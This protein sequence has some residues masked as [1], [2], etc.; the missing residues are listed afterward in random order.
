MAGDPAK[1]EDTATNRIVHVV[2]LIVR[3]RPAEDSERR[4]LW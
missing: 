1:A 3:E 4:L 2:A